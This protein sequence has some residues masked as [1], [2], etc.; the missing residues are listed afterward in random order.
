MTSSFF[1]SLCQQ[2]FAFVKEAAD[3]LQLIFA[4]ILRWAIIQ[5]RSMSRSIWTWIM[6]A[7]G[8]HEWARRRKKGDNNC[9]FTAI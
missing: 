1:W 5:A 7:A 6:N 3:I 9:S 4:S 8:Q 2:A